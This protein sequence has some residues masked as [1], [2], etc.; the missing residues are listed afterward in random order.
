MPSP[1]SPRLPRTKTWSP[2]RERHGFENTWVC[3][4]SFTPC[5]LLTPQK[6]NMGPKN[7]PNEKENYLP[8]LHFFWD[9]CQFFLL[10]HIT[11]FRAPWNVWIFGKIRLP[12]KNASCP[13]HRDLASW[14]YTCSRWERPPQAIS[15]W[16]FRVYRDTIVGSPTK[17]VIT[18]VLVVTVTGQVLLP[19]GFGYQP[20]LGNN[21]LVWRSHF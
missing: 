17:N 12:F 7:Y 10:G 13:F 1:L 20:Y 11:G 2:A 6:I 8:N 9:S 3:L 21:D 4:G 15:R 19:G 16:L 5:T 14:H 18:L